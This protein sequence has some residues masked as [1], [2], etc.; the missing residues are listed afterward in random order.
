MLINVSFEQPGPGFSLG[1][2][3]AALSVGKET[4]PY[5]SY[6]GKDNKKLTSCA[7]NQ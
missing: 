7:T 6:V 1:K 3:D 5:I 4:L 2:M